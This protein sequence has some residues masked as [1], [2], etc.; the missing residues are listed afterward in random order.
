MKKVLAMILTVAMMVMLAACGS[1]AA[2]GNSGSNSGSATNTAQ[3]DSDAAKTPEDDKITIGVTCADLTIPAFTSITNI[4]S[5]VCEENDVGLT[6]L[7]ANRDPSTQ[8]TQMEN[9]IQN[10]TDVIII[11]EPVDTDAL[12]TVTQQAKDAGICVIGF[13]IAVP[14][15]T[16][17]LI[18]PNEIIG[19]ELGMMCVDWC[20]KNYPG[21]VVEVGFIHDRLTTPA[22]Y[23]R[24]NGVLRAF[25]ENPDVVKVVSEQVT[26]TTEEGMTYTESMIQGNP[27]MKVVVSATGGG[28]IGANEAFKAHG[29]TD[30]SKY[31]VFSVDTTP[32]ILTLLVS[33]DEPLQG[34]MCVGSDKYMAETMFEMSMKFVNGESYDEHWMTKQQQVKV[35]NVRDYIVN[36][37]I[38]FDV[39]AVK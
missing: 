37:E 32:D 38:D 5:K 3:G 29:C 20:K 9:F 14:G 24:P 21:E 33:G 36:E 16:M 19:Y 6:L 28:G 25:D 34:T 10:K 11:I 12:A 27:N 2:Q 13:G 17:D 23:D 7:S 22:S 18:C 31:P 26:S 30:Q 4:L 35:D 1:N 15:N 8:V 39:N